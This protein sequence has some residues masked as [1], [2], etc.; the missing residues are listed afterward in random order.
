MRFRSPPRAYPTL[1]KAVQRASADR[2]S[3]RAASFTGDL[4]FTGRGRRARFAT[5]RSL[6]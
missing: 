1:A 5:A 6:P 2:A 4:S 3:S